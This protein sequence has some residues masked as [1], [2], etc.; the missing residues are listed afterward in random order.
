MEKKELHRKVLENI[1]SKG[2]TY[3]DVDFD[4][5]GI[6]NSHYHILNSKGGLI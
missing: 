2:A 3:K 5:S 1:S 4:K 6:V